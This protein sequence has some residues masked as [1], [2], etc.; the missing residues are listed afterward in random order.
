MR[1]EEDA[2]NVWLGLFLAL[3]LARAL[4]ALL[5]TLF[6]Q[7]LATFRLNHSAWWMLALLAPALAP[8]LG[9]RG[10]R[11]ALLVAGAATAALPFARFTP[12]YVPLA[13][14]AS[15]AG[16]VALARTASLA[17]FVAG[18]ALDGALLVLGSSVEPSAFLVPALA[19]VGALWAARRAA[20]PAPETHDLAAG[21]GAAALVA[22]ELAFL[23]SP[24][25]AAR[26]AGIPAW[27]A[28]VAGGL[29]L[30]AGATRFR[31]AGHWVWIVGALGLVDLVLAR[32]PFVALSLALV[33]LALGCAAARLAP[34]LASVGGSV[35][36]ALLLAPL[37]FVLLYFGNQ[38]GVS[39]WGLQVPLLALL[40]A[41]PA[42]FAARAM[43]L[44]R[45]TGAI[46]AAL[47]VLASAIGGASSQPDPPP[48]SP[49]ELR[50]ASWNVHQGFGNRGALDPHLYA[51]VLR[52]LDADIVVLQESDT[53][54]LSSGGLDIVNFL[55][56]E[57]DMH[58]A[59]GR[60]G[61]AVLSRLPFADEPRPAEE[62]WSFEVA[63]DVEGATLWVHGVHLARGRFADE[64]VAQVDAL[65]AEP[66]RA[67]HVVAGDFNTCAAGSSLCAGGFFGTQ[68]PLFER[69]LARYQDAWTEAGHDVD[70][71]TGFTIRA[72]SPS[73]RIDH[74]LVEG[75]EVVAIEVVLTD[76]TRAASD[77]LPQ[78]LTF[79]V[80][81]S[82]R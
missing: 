64:R 19:T 35:A 3:L 1:R 6:Y 49:D 58:A 50:L 12:G 43:R 24:F 81:S 73:R 63:L 82:A 34:G 41:T 80:P 42:L 27:L 68:Q 15:A 20:R 14:L 7:S 65:L 17:G 37:A 46:A 75:V 32:S 23:A 51:E 22:L 74:V 47:L 67:H 26:W 77:H 70:D 72:S 78:V 31:D 30:V 52:R 9:R 54:R 33:Q 25:A 59:Y 76:D 55:A 11:A 21:A 57:L 56:D 40:A 5:S 8:L 10:A 38:L 60:S 45:R 79:R 2:A 28:A 36:F 18:L 39:E 13:A 71:P 44:P 62:D 16:L 4:R 29:G 48:P 53:A 66:P 61:A 69:L